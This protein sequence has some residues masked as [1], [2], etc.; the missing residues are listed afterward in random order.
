MQTFKASTILLLSIAVSVVDALPVPPTC[1]T[2]FLQAYLYPTMQQTT[3]S[4][5]VTSGYPEPLAFMYATVDV[6]GISYPNQKIWCVDY[7]QYVFTGTLYPTSPV[8]SYEYIVANPTLATGIDQAGRLNQVAFLLNTIVIGTSVA[9]PSVQVWRN[10][11]YTGCSIITTSD[12]QAVV[13]A[14]VQKPGECD[15]STGGALCTT[16]L[17]SV[18]SCNVAYLW[19]LAFANVPDNTPY[20]VP[21]N[22]CAHTVVYP[23]VLIPEPP[24]SQ[25]TQVQIVTVEIN[26]S[27]TNYSCGRLGPNGSPT[28]TECPAGHYC[29]SGPTP[30]TPIVPLPCPAGYYC[31]PGSCN[32]TACP[33][34]YKCPAGSSE[35]IQCQP[36]YYCPGTRNSNMTLCPIGYMC[37]QPG[38]C[39][40]TVCPNGTFVT[41]SGKTWCSPCSAGRYCPSPTMSVLCPAG[42][43]CPS[44]SSAPTQ[45]PASHYCPLGSAT[46]KNCS[47]GQTSAAGSKSTSQCVCDAFVLSVYNVGH[48]LSS[49][50]DV[51]GLP[52]IG[53]A[54]T[55]VIYIPDGY[56]NQYW[57][58]LV[59]GTP[60]FYFAATW[61]GSFQVVSGGVYQF[62]AG[63]ND[64]SILSIDGS[65]VVNNDGIHTFKT[66]YG[67]AGL[68]PGQHSVSV[69]F[70]QN[71]GFSGISIQWSGPDTG[72]AWSLLQS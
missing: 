43:Y 38:M 30:S 6:Q 17:L 12:F 40:P 39:S 1:V 42:S 67:A 55:N 61:T 32:A 10:K 3:A 4:F 46:P 8:Y 72:G 44:G 59:P 35:P 23:F 56:G 11:T 60:D 27:C 19:N 50:P 15:R 45:C 31:P 21:T 68:V 16:D 48:S 5:I 53:T 29:P 49:V 36:P 63:S 18:N 25:T 33:C 22:S 28:Q 20:S 14:L 62:A 57:T 9:T 34:G 51:S 26:C 13:W 65:V 37:D 41:C 24:S 69:G 71:E 2:S 52:L 47:S 58:A 66:L 64:G 54:C 7:D 70:F